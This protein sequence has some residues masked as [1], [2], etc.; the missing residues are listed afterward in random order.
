MMDDAAFALALA[1]PD[2]PRAA[3]AALE[4]MSRDRTGHRLFTLMTLDAAAGL[5]RRAWTN[6][7]SAYPVSGAKPIED[8]DWSR[9]VLGRH[10]TWVM[11]SVDHI[12][13]HFPDHAL[14]ASLGCGACL[15]LPVVVAGRVLGTV[16]ILG[17]AGHFTAARI[18]AAESL[19][20][21]AAAAFLI[22]AR[23]DQ[24]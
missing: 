8:N 9:A 14:I 15:N 23:K 20:L 24:P 1:A 19:R 5:A 2:Q 4:E 13:Q 10:E 16:N 22:A 12:A 6:M 7:G 11:N 18:A 21:P 17:P 3:F